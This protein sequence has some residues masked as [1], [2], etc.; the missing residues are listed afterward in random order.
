MKDSKGDRIGGRVSRNGA[1][2]KADSDPNGNPAISGRGD[3][4][5]AAHALPARTSTA[6]EYLS[7]RDDGWLRFIPSRDGS[8]VYCKWKFTSGP[9]QN[10]YVMSVGQYWQLDYIFHLLLRKLDDVDA[11]NLDPLAADRLY[12]HYADEVRHD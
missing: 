3:R 12:N 8:P 1:R 6:L 11:G 7:Q 5:S 4:A 9:H 2:G 10:C